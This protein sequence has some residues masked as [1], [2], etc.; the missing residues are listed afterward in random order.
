[1]DFDRIVRD[2][3]GLT[4]RISAQ[5]DVGIA[6]VVEPVE[7]D[8]A[9]AGRAVESRLS[10]GDHSDDRV[11]GVDEGPE[12]VDGPGGLEPVPLGHQPIAGGVA[13]P[14]PRAVHE[15]KDG[16]LGEPCVDRAAVEAE[17]GGLP[18]SGRVDVRERGLRE[19]VAVR[20]DERCAGSSSSLASAVVLQSMT[21]CVL[22][23]RVIREQSPLPT[24][25]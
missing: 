13:Q 6:L 19:V 7:R 22:S 14:A 4:E 9:S 16:V 12:G 8:E 20:I 1:M 15:I 23:L 10:F 25:K 2:E 24:G 18:S 11:G 5:A 17:P 21:I 3:R